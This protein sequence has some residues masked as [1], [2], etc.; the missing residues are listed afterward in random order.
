[1][2]LEIRAFL[3][4]HAVA[5]REVREVLFEE[6]EE[7]ALGAR[8]EEERGGAEGAR[9]GLGCGF[10]DGLEARLAVIDQRE[11]GMR[12]DRRADAGL[13]ESADGREAQ[14]GARR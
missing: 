2:A 3:D 5:A 6:R 7:H 13:R 9:S 8:F 1:M 12:Q 4:T 10:G 11:D 14:G